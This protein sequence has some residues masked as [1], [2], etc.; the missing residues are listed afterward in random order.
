MQKPIIQYP[1]EF[2]NK[3]FN[4]LRHFM[5]IRLLTTA[6]DN[7]RDTIVRY[8]LEEALEDPTLYV[9]QIVDDGERKIANAK[10]HAHKQRQ[11][12]YNTYMDLLIQTEEKHA[13]RKLL[14]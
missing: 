14:R 6:M 10:I 3:C 2:K 7:S 4:H 13:T 8:Y 12:L 9:D 11:E 5:D 1:E